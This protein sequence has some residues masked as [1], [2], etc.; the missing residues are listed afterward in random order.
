MQAALSGLERIFQV[1]AL[2]SETLPSGSHRRPERRDT[3]AIE[4]REV[5]FGYRPGLPVMHGVTLEVRPGE[6]VAFRLSLGELG[7]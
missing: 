2:P 4:M 6:H 5:S 7:G 1:L 3:P